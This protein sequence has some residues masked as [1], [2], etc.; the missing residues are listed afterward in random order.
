M[1][2]ALSKSSL[3]SA[4]ATLLHCV[5]VLSTTTFLMPVQPEKASLPIDVTVAGTVS[6]S[7]T[8]TPLKAPAAIAV[9]LEGITNSLT[10]LLAGQ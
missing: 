4:I 3:P 8:V 6:F 9:T 1:K 5:F 7:I 2:I 10:A